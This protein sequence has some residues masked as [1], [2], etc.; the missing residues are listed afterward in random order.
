MLQHGDAERAVE[1]A[2]NKRQMAGIGR[3]ESGARVDTAD[4][5]ACLADTILIMV[6]A[7][8]LELRDLQTR[9]ADLG[10]ADATADI[11]NAFARLRL[12]C[13]CSRNSPKASFH[14]R[15]RTCLSVREVRASRPRTMSARPN[16]TMLGVHYR[17]GY[18][19][20]AA[21]WITLKREARSQKLAAES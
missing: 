1:S 13:A 16:C 4:A 6:D 8:Q 18:S 2:V 7:K 21:G 19:L 10:R 15:S 14:Q 3:G 20:L 12:E 9:Q 17:S 5:T 11:Q